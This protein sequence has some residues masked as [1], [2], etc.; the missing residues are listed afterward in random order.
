MIVKARLVCSYSPVPVP[1]S[2]LS[3]MSDSL[4]TPT[5]SGPV[6]R[7]SVV[8]S[9]PTIEMILKVPDMAGKSSHEVADL[10]LRSEEF[11]VERALRVL[12]EGFEQRLRNHNKVDRS[13]LTE[14]EVNSIFLNISQIYEFNRRLYAEL[15]SLRLD[16]RLVEEV[17]ACMIKHLPF[18]KLYSHYIQEYRKAQACVDQ[19]VEKKRK[20][21]E[22]LELNEL[23][24]G[25]ALKTL[26][27]AP[28]CRLPQY[29]Q[30]LGGI[31]NSADP[32]SEAAQSVEAAIRAVQSVTDE[33]AFN[34]RDQVSRRLVV[35]VQQ[36]IFKNNCDLISPHRFVI[37]HSDLKKVYNH[38]LRHVT[39]GKIYL[40]VLMCDLLL[41]GTKPGKLSSGELKH[42]LQLQGLRIEDVPDTEKVRNAFRI[43]SQTKNFVVSAQN[44]PM[45]QSWMSAIREAVAIYERNSGTLQK[46]QMSPDEFEK[47][48]KRKPQTAA[49]AAAMAAQNQ[50]SRPAGSAGAG[51]SAPAPLSVS[52]YSSMGVPSSTASAPAAPSNYSTMSSYDSSSYSSYS[53]YDSQSQSSGHSA[54]APNAYS[55]YDAQLYGSGNGYDDQ[56][57]ASQYDTNNGNSSAYG[58]MSM[59]TPPLP[60]VPPRSA[61]AI[62]VPSGPPPSV[63]LAPPL[64]P[65]PGS[66]SGPA[67]PPAPP[68]SKPAAPRGKSNW[69]AVTDPDSGQVYYENTVTGESQWDKPADFQAESS[70]AKSSSARPAGS[71]NSSS[72][73]G[74]SFEDDAHGALKATLDRYRMFVQAEEDDIRDND[75]EWDG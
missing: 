52:S 50:T 47:M 9:G 8:G 64:P 29:L 61:P 19:L 21:D 46:E 33:I 27:L 57:N 54:A 65:V 36:K 75:E 15:L 22:F 71:G 23:C 72:N 70:G 51:A 5:D 60:N 73:K 44:G 34:L 12:S 41:Y 10:F 48:I 3:S 66:G 68:M 18:F 14:P 1:P 74:A 42:V 49:Q 67:P 58:T 24:A 30:F 53:S 45:K 55:T 31:L 11:Y 16:M 7:R 13:V 26:L 39:T 69:V 62:P 35:T 37:K 56:A 17:G 6:Q 63:P 2:P 28:V 43:S 59:S 40:F 4:V 20:F 38:Q 32:T 25:H